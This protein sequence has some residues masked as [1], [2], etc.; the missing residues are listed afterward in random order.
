MFILENEKSNPAGI[1]KSSNHEYIFARRHD[2]VLASIGKNITQECLAN[3]QWVTRK[4]A[5]FICVMMDCLLRNRGA[6]RSMIKR[7]L[8]F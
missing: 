1:K 5:I 8:N 4:F 6:S 3:V 7:S 2:Q